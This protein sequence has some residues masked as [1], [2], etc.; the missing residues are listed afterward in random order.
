MPTIRRSFAVFSITCLLALT[1]S[2]VHQQSHG[3][4]ISYPHKA[5][6]S[7]SVGV[8]VLARAGDSYKLSVVDVIRND[9]GHPLKRGTPIDLDIHAIG[10]PLVYGAPSLVLVLT[11]HD[12]HWVFE[13][14]DYAIWM[15]MNE[16]RLYHVL[17]PHWKNSAILEPWNPGLTL[18]EIKDIANGCSKRTP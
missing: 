7:D 10:G 1:A 6:R 14:R 9:T 16:D 8:F 15:Y 18:A 2:C 11:C 5:S 17:I 12:G 3:R 4:V 13:R